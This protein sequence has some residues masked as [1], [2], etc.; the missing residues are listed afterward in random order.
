M[1]GTFKGKNWELCKVGLHWSELFPGKYGSV[2]KVYILHIVRPVGEGLC[3][4]TPVPAPVCCKQ[5]T[6][7]LFNMSKIMSEQLHTFNRW[8]LGFQL[9]FPKVN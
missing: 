3:N 7:L 5:N 2:P 6:V 4:H 8:L 1:E 9:D